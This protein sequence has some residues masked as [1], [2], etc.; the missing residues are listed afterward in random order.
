[1]TAWKTGEMAAWTSTK[2]PNYLDPQVC[3]QTC[4]HIVLLSIK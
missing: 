4:Y 1:M 2:T 3:D